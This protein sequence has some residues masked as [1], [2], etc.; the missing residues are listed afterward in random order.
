[1]SLDS[2]GREN[3]I[4]FISDTMTGF[5]SLMRNLQ[6]DYRTYSRNYSEEALELLSRSYG[7]TESV[8]AIKTLGSLDRIDD[9]GIDK[10]TELSIQIAELYELR[11][12]VTN[13]QVQDGGKFY[14][15]CGGVFYIDARDTGVT[16]S[17][18]F[19]DV[20][21]ETT[22]EEDR[23]FY[24]Q[25]CR[26][27]LG[28]DDPNRIS[29]EYKVNLKF[30]GND[31]TNEDNE[32]GR[33]M[34]QKYISDRF[35]EKGAEGAASGRMILK[36]FDYEHGTS[37]CKSEN[38][39][40]KKAETIY[41]EL[42]PI[43]EKN[44]EEL[45]AFLNKI[46]VIKLVDKSYLANE[47]IPE[48]KKLSEIPQKFAMRWVEIFKHM[49]IN[50]IDNFDASDPEIMALL[51]VIYDF[52]ERLEKF[53]KQIVFLF[54]AIKIVIV[55]FLIDKAVKYPQTALLVL[56]FYI[57]VKNDVISLSEILQK[58][59]LK[60]IDYYENGIGKKFDDEGTY[61]RHLFGFKSDRNGKQ[62]DHYYTTEGSLQSKMGFMDYYD[63]CGH[64]LGMDG[65]QDIVITFPYKD[66]EYRVEFWYGPYGY[67]NAYGAEIGIYYRDLSDALEKPYIEKK[68][69]ESEEEKKKR[70]ENNRF[71][72]YDCVP[73]GDQFWLRLR[74]EDKKGNLDPIINDVRKY[75]KN[76]DHF[77]NLAI[78][79]NKLSVKD[80]TVIGEISSKDEKLTQIMGRAIKN[81]LQKTN[82]ERCVI[83]GNKIIVIIKE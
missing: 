9:D 77:W 25:I 36:D 8:N 62:I 6:E 12:T 37:I 60:A 47:L 71:I 61:I 18:I 50:D 43:N 38:E 80:M 14:S 64:L 10:L 22:W 45:F 67:G 20:F 68:E 40:Y 3:K 31:E 33:I 21:K 35:A 72:L 82:K 48:G 73:E 57:L 17:R 23:D 56:V 19:K 75:A 74:I 53:H 52:K 46:Q 2:A 59:E 81:K 39:N 5:Y 7:F 30:D 1:M 51:R 32:F 4:R 16:I 66:K 65:L 63:E 28:I 78:R 29:G 13:G 69:E 58:I 49:N 11:T 44:R 55:I 70:L 54:N 34:R 24:T 26:K 41:D 83:E 79:T 76:G 42:V 15:F 27:C